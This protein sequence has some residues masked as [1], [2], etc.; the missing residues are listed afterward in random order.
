VRD[1][2]S[3]GPTYGGREKF[4][5]KN[6]SK[7]RGRFSHTR[8]EEAASQRPLQV[9]VY[10]SNQN[11]SAC[12]RRQSSLGCS[13]RPIR[14][15]SR[16]QALRSP[17]R[18]ADG[19]RRFPPPSRLVGE[20]GKRPSQPGRR[21]RPQLHMQSSFALRSG[22]LL[23]KGRCPRIDAWKAKRECNLNLAG[24]PSHA[25]VI[26]TQRRRRPVAVWCPV[27]SARYLC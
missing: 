15:P 9:E 17:F 1:R 10:R 13:L 14:I 18:K 26:A 21:C 24:E 25:T 16:T 22:V 23:S 3:T 5:R 19:S 12:A 4:I 20:P 11:Q 27:A 6:C 7:E 8:K 2:R